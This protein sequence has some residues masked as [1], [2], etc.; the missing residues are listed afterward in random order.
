MQCYVGLSHQYRL[1]GNLTLDSQECQWSPDS[2]ASQLVDSWPCIC[3]Q[4]SYLETAWDFYW[5]GLGLGINA[6][7]KHVRLPSSTLW[8]RMAQMIMP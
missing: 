6:H 4:W 2:L 3:Q 8:D 1:Q 5:L 7:P